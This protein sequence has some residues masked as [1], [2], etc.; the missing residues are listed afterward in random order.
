MTRDKNDS[1]KRLVI[2]KMI[3]DHLFDAMQW[4]GYKEPSCLHFAVSY[5]DKAES[6]IEILEVHDCKSVGGFDIGQPHPE[7]IFDRW[8]WL[9][10][11]YHNPEKLRFACGLSTYR[12]LRDYFKE[13]EL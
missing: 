9:F 8:D 12:E 7:N 2:L 11:K 5:Y 10:R 13:E 4:S 3:G 6:L 1:V